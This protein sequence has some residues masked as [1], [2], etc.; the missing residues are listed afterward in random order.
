[1]TIAPFGYVLFV[2]LDRYGLQVTIWETLNE[3]E[4]ALRDVAASIWPDLR[5]DEI[6]E[7]FAEAG[8]RV[9][10]YAC[11]VKRNVQSSAELQPFTGAASAVA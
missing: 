2:E 10:L 4:A 11:T 5:D 7:V 1:M 6:V 9:H 8:G 3:A